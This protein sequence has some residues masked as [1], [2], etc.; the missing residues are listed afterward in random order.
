MCPASPTLLE[1][2]GRDKSLS[3][4]LLCGLRKNASSKNIPLYAGGRFPKICGGY[5]GGKPL[6]ITIYSSESGRIKRGGFMRAISGR[7]HS[8]PAKQ[9]AQ[10]TP[11]DV[12]TPP[13]ALK[14]PRWIPR[15]RVRSKLQEHPWQTHRDGNGIQYKYIRHMTSVGNTVDR[16]EYDLPQFLFLH[17]RGRPIRPLSSTHRNRPLRNNTLSHMPKPSEFMR[18][19]ITISVRG[20]VL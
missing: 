19:C 6:Q 15:S 10:A 5:T 9:G 2:Q 14:N 20:R 7:F 13:R 1:S 12:E 4:F 17:A 16:I 8:L 11:K 3:Y 18:A